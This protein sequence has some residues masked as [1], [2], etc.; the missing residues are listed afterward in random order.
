MAATEITLIRRLIEQVGKIAESLCNRYFLYGEYT[1]VFDGDGAK[2]LYLKGYPVITFSKLEIKDV[3]GN[4]G[5]ISAADYSV[6]LDLGEIY[7]SSGF[8]EGFQN[9]RATYTSG[10]AALDV[11]LD[12]D[13]SSPSGSP[14][15]DDCYIVK[16][17]GTGDWL[18][19]DNE[20]TQYDGSGWV[21]TTPSKKMEVYVS[22]EGKV[23]Q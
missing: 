18:N 1:E 21:F 11:V 22:E 20:I 17:P 10:Y 16:A 19:H 5:E 9:I 15:T 3:D 23:Y 14:S 13:Q 12:K 4:F 6:N 7:Y 2:K 8:S